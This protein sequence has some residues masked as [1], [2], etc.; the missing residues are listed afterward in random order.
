MEEYKIEGKKEA[1][2]KK[3]Q[4]KE[5]KKEKAG[6][7]RKRGEWNLERENQQIQWAAHT[8]DCF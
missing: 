4:E 2:V 5:A 1:N 8:V 6:S 3:A 7:L